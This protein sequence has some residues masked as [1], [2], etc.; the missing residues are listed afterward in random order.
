VWHFTTQSFECQVKYTDTY[1]FTSRQTCSTLKCCIFYVHVI[2]CLL[3]TN[4]INF[5]HEWIYPLFYIIHPP[6][7]W[8]KHHQG[9]HSFRGS[10]A[11]RNCACMYIH[12]WCA[13]HTS[14]R[15]LV[16][17]VFNTRRLGSMFHTLTYVLCVY[18]YQ[19]MCVYTHTH[20]VKILKLKLK[21]ICSL[22]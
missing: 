22:W 4:K 8:L 2:Q 5:P 1:K 3:T 20:T 14:Y 21:P 12:W 15:I 7:L 9:N 11:S 17:M 18:R 19:C 10:E 16:V 6:R 13:S